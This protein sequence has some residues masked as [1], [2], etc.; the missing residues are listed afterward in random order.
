MPLTYPYQALRKISSLRYP[1]L[2]S[3]VERLADT[4]GL[5][6]AQEVRLQLEGISE[7]SDVLVNRIADDLDATDSVQ[8]LRTTLTAAVEA[9]HH[10]ITSIENLRELALTGATFRRPQ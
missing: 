9:E 5:L 2:S 4:S 3:A 10:H 6:S 7:L 1:D 8:W